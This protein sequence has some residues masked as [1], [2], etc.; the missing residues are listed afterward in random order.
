M[1]LHELVHNDRIIGG[2]TEQ[3]TERAIA[4]YRIFCEGKVL[5]TSVRAAELCKLTENAF[6]DVN[7]EAMSN[8][9]AN[10]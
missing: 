3:C 2:M 6:R 7:R 10:R 5:P 1:V 9:A 8:G 4:F